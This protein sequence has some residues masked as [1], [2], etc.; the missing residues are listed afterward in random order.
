MDDQIPQEPFSEAPREQA[1]EPAV[2]PTPAESR[3]LTDP[4]LGPV[5]EDPAGTTRR[6]QFLH[7]LYILLSLT[8]AAFTLTAW[9]LIRIH[10]PVGLLSTGPRD[11]ARA[12]LRALDRGELRVAY[13]MFSPRYRAQVSFNVWNQLVLS[14]WRIFHAEVLGSD[15]PAQSG[16]RVILEMHLRGADD[17]SYRA[18]FTLVHAAGRWWIDDLHWADE[19]DT[20]DTIQI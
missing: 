19:P 17:R 3:P 20:R 13:E 11:V 18:R 2:T 16:A 8:L 10:V 7:N 14:H 5:M 9:I 15:E 1:S 6:R 4:L 12:Q